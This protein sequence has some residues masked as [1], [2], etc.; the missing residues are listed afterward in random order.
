MPGLSEAKTMHVIFVNFYRIGFVEEP[1]R[2]G[3]LIEVTEINQLRVTSWKTL[4]KKLWA[5]NMIQ[6]LK[7]KA[8]S[9]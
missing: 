4:Q 7:T 6:V 5:K 8:F 2:V 1:S 9:I 3:S